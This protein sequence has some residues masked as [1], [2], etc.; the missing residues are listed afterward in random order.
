M[1]RIKRSFFENE[2]QGYF[3]ELP[4]GMQ[5]L[6]KGLVL[7]AAE[8]RGG[9]DCYKLDAEALSS[10]EC[11]SRDGFIASSANRGGLIY[12]NFTDLMSYWGGGYSVSHDAAQK[13]IERQIELSLKDASEST[14]NHFKPFFDAHKIKPEQVNYHHLQDL[15]ERAG[16]N[17]FDEP[18]Q[19]IQDAELECLGGDQSSIMH[20]L[21][22]LYHGKE[23]GVHSA[24]VSAAVNTEGPYHRSSISWA[25]GVFCEGSKELEITWRTQKELKTKLT[26]ALAK[27]SKA[28]F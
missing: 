17:T 4:K 10:I 16:S 7:E 21:R 26:K 9:P 20:E 19:H 8:N 13:E 14:Y 25:P 28:V 24:S 1:K 27:V 12:Q 23:N 3:E 18:I 6:I 5:E 15:A 2:A 22:F 11:Q